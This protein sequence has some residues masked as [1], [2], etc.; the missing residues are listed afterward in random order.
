MQAVTRLHHVSET[1]F[2]TRA[3]SLL[4]AF[5][6]SFP[7]IPSRAVCG[8]TLCAVCGDTL[9]AVLALRSV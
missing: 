6:H 9:C 3:L 8:V 2:F 5:V 7:F 4:I 1:L